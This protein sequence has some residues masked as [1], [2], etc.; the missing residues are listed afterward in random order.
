MT[1]ALHDANILIDVL[2]VQL[3]DATLRLPYTMHTT[4]FVL[5]EL[6]PSQQAILA[7]FIEQ[8]ILH[9]EEIDGAGVLEIAELFD[10][11][12][13]LSFTDCSVCLCARNKAAI[14]L[15]GDQ[16]LRTI[17]ESYGISVRGMLWIFDELIRA[18]LL[19]PSDAAE[20]LTFLLQQ[21]RRL[22]KQECTKR[23]EQWKL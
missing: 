12:K 21:G 15:T 17:A 20:K 22:P 16:A 3:V 2:T 13:A 9:V 11:H 7:P 10:K 5:E 18:K 4:P 23:L 14:L 19:A 1:I 8:G 6:Y